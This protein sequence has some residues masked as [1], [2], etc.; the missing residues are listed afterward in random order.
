MFFRRKKQPDADQSVLTEALRSLED[1][2]AETPETTNT[3]TGQKAI[4]TEP[5][6]ANNGNQSDHEGRLDYPQHSDVA[7]EDQ[8]PEVNEDQIPEVNEDQMPDVTENR[9]PEVNE[10]Q[11]QDFTEDQ[12]PEITGNQVPEADEDRT[13]HVTEDQV[14]NIT[15]DDD[16]PVLTNVAYMPIPRV[17][18]GD[19]ATAPQSASIDSAHQTIAKQLINAVEDRLDPSGEPLDPALTQDLQDAVSASLEEW[20]VRTQEILLKRFTPPTKK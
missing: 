9:V 11:M 13:L 15:S 7:E 1:L 10:N 5:H 20:S 18:A 19:T 8:I 12:A 16:V 17:T 3:D 2:I 6:E 4:A 14:P